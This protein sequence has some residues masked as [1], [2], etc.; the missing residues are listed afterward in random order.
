MAKGPRYTW[1]GALQELRR[2]AA[3][4]EGCTTE[5][6]SAKTERAHG[7]VE[8]CGVGKDELREAE[9][10]GGECQGATAE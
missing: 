4:N 9:K 8:L 3:V 1:T 2:C 7:M 5:P 6:M 10:R